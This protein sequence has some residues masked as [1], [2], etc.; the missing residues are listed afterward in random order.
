MSWSPRPVICCTADTRP[1][2]NSPWPATIARGCAWSAEGVGSLL[3][4]FRKISQDVGGLTHLAHQPLV[5]SLGR[6]DAAVLQ[7]VV[8]GDDFGDHGDVLP[9]I[10][11][12]ANL[13][14]LDVE[15]R[16]R[17]RVEARSVDGGVLIPL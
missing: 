9:W 14:E 10:E 6:I 1:A 16:R 17:H 7:Q 13:R 8:E 2:A 11:R 15:D 3:I 4:V 12:D 5:K